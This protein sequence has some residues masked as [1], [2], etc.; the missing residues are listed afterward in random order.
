M[1]YNIKLKGVCSVSNVMKLHRET[2]NT[3]SL[4]KTVRYNEEQFVFL[5]S[6]YTTE[7]N[8]CIS[9]Y[10][11]DRIVNIGIVVGSLVSISPLICVI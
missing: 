1:Y 7:D 3:N 8:V 6:V 2:K 11:N 5:F 4:T 9:K 10:P